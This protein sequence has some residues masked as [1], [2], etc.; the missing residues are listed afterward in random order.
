M[1]HDACG[2]GFIARMAGEA[3]HDIVR[4]GLTAL[5][6]LA[7]RGAPAS[8]GAVD[9]CGVLTAIPWPLLTASLGGR[10]PAGRSRA[11][12]M[13]FVAPAS[14][15]A[16]MALVERELRGGRRAPHVASGADR[17]QRGPARPA[18]LDP[19]RAAGGHRVRRRAATRLTSASIRA[20]MRHFGAVGP[21]GPAARRR[22]AL[23]D[24]RW[25]TRRWSRRRPWRSF[26]PDLAD[27]A[28]RVARS[29][30]SISAIS[31]NTS[32]D[33]ALAQPFRL[34]AHNGE[35]NTIAGNRPWMRAR[36]LDSTSIARAGQTA[37]RCPT[38]PRI[39]GSLDEAVDLLRH[40]GYS[41]AH[42]VSR[43]MPP[44]WE[45]DRELRARRPR[46]SR[47][48]VARR[49]SRGTGRRRSRSPTAASSAPLWTAT[50]SGRRASCRTAAGLM[51][52][53]SEVGVLDAAEHEIVDRGRLGPGDMLDGRPRARRRDGDQRDHAPARVPPPLPPPG[54]R[55][56]PVA[57]RRRGPDA[58][59]CA[60]A[61]PGARIG[62][63]PTLASR[64]T[65]LRR[66]RARK[67]D[68]L[69]RPMV[70]RGTRSRRL[71]GRRHAAGGLVA[72]VAALHRFLPP[73]VRTGNQSA[74]RS[75]S[76]VAR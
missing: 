61:R 1:Q 67:I 23:D 16:G 32:A 17:P 75:V 70:D 28:L 41:I 8:L 43:L 36:L 76:R 11:L 27:H 63:P 10:L 71:D 2:V 55:H 58:D 25:F 74:G 38:A 59:R 62:R 18:R 24:A 13:L 57:V 52:V 40:R 29:S 7:H 14:R 44:A 50:A 60:R 37:G 47:V 51:A 20:R 54:R 49:A 48:P 53:A 34:L 12:G 66:V 72:E 31:T 68:L 26:Y 39:R 19:A 73:A 64:Q 6:R 5:V 30:C 9:G 33:W 3:G 15:E 45:R 56:A 42:A 21:P 69:L 46:L 22:F 65:A 35:I 4:H